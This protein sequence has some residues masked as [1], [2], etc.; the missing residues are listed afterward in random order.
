VRVAPATT[1]PEGRYDVGVR[2][3]GGSTG[4]RG[5]V[6]TSEGRAARSW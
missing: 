2:L 1:S 5:I 6:S 3:V 4:L